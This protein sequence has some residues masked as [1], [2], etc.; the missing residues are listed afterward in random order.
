MTIPSCFV[1]I[2]STEKD[3]D[4]E[5]AGR[6]WA[7]CLSSHLGLDLTLTDD[8][9]IDT[10][11]AHDSTSMPDWTVECHTSEF[12]YQRQIENLHH[13]V[14]VVSIGGGHYVPKMNDLVRF[15]NSCVS[16]PQHLIFCLL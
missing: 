5:R 8:P 2:G 16:F 13:S 3:W 15:Q 6:M 12:D 10:V 9:T 11:Q 4:C 7:F 1:E 14:V